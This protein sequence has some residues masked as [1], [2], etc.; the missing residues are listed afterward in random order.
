ML[1]KEAYEVLRLKE[2]EMENLRIEIEAL[3]IA[4][5]RA[6]VHALGRA[7]AAVPGSAG[8]ELRPATGARPG[9]EG[10]NRGLPVATGLIIR[11]LRFPVGRLPRTLT[12]WRLLEDRRCDGSSCFFLPSRSLGR[13]Q[14]KG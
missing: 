14:R 10:K 9:V 3:R 2:L 5:T 7:A 4:A 11:H 1:T 12:L 8:G 13:R 6:E